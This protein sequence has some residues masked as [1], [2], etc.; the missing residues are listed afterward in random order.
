MPATLDDLLRFLH[1]QWPRINKNPEELKIYFAGKRGS[2]ETERDRDLKKTA[3]HLLADIHDESLDDQ[4]RAGEMTVAR[5]MARFASL[6]VLLSIQADRQ[7]R[8]NLSIQRWLIGLTV[9]LVFLTIA[10]LVLT[11][12]MVP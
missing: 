10:L 3:E 2:A 8:Q 9:V 7:A 11:W 1:E 4:S 5:T 12:K 6:L